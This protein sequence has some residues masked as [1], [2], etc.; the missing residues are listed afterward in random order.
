M[1]N[2][3]HC[4]K[5]ETEVPAGFSLKSLKIWLLLGPISV[6]YVLSCCIIKKSNVLTVSC[7][8]KLIY[9]T[10]NYMYLR[11]A[12]RWPRNAKKRSVGL[13]DFNMNVSF[14]AWMHLVDALQVGSSW[15]GDTL[16]VCMQHSCV[17]L[18]S[19]IFDGQSWIQHS[20]LHYATCHPV[21]LRWTL[22]RNP[23][24]ESLLFK[25]W[26][27]DAD[28]PEVPLKLGV[29]VYSPKCIT[30]VAALIWDL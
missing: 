15:E 2:Y 6:L 14:T 29:C 24:Y 19:T 11:Y 8:V 4:Q 23:T 21:T 20:T 27:T 22:P 17:C 7:S 16:T 12:P 10:I 5:V 18:E 28:V 1:C 3:F 25:Q 26:W 13:E 30:A 9:F